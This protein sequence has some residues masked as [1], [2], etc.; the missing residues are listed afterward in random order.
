MCRRKDEDPRPWK[1]ISENGDEIRAMEK[2]ARNPKSLPVSDWSN[3]RSWEY[4]AAQD[5]SD[6]SI[7]YALRS[8]R[9]GGD[10]AAANTK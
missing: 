4:I 9:P 7:L 2:A 6:L 1:L 3:F 10:W 8:L 5:Q